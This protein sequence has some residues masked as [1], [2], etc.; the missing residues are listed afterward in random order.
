M[1][2]VSDGEWE[3]LGDYLRRTATPEFRLLLE[4]TRRGYRIWLTNDLRH[5]QAQLTRRT[6]QVATRKYRARKGRRR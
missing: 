5:T 1:Q 3:P 6:V 2:P 4:R